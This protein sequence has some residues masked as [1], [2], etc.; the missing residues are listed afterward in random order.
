MTLQYF[1]KAFITLDTKVQLFVFSAFYGPKKRIL[2]FH[3]PCPKFFSFPNHFCNLTNEASVE[4][5]DNNN[6]SAK[7]KGVKINIL[8]CLMY[9]LLVNSNSICWWQ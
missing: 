1:S 5:S 9:M 7:D 8:I 3:R 6:K 4:T 2:Q